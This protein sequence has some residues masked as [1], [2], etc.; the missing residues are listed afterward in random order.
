[1][2]QA[3]PQPVWGWD[4]RLPLFFSR[5]VGLLVVGLYCLGQ[6]SATCGQVFSGKRA[7]ALLQQQVEL[8]PRVPGT[9]ANR[10]LRDLILATA[11]DY[12]FAATSVCLTVTDP[13]DG[14][15]V[16]IC[17]VVVTIPGDGQ[18]AA[19][20]LWLGTHFDTRP[21]SDQDPNPARRG[22]PV[23]GANDGASGTAILLHLMDLMRLEAPAT[24]VNLLF[25]DGE[26][27]GTSAA[28]TGYCLG[29]R[30]LAETWSDFGSPLAGPTPRGLVLLDMVGGKGLQIPIEG[31]SAQYAPQW[32]ALVFDRAN[33]LGLEAFVAVPGRPIYDDHVAFLEVGIP[34]VDLI[35]FSYPQWHT[36]DDLPGFCS[37]QSLAQVGTL[38]WDLVRHP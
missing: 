27:S 25:F 11:Q 29:S 38:V 7:F 32:A 37:P 34:A 26:D 12:S 28:V 24:E 15:P 5:T 6:S 2:L 22:L 20:R 8:G 19:G 23:P 10:A 17:N 31:Y 1:M 9:A 14:E 13:L 35:D 30:H 18:S 36:T 33:A 4:W 3:E 21:I 16:E